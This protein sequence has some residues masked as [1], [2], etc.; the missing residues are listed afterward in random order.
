MLPAR[1]RDLGISGDE[2][3]ARYMEIIAHIAE[4]YILGR[5]LWFGAF[6]S[7]RFGADWIRSIRLFYNYA[8]LVS[9]SMFLDVCL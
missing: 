3:V 4:R 7:C 2:M 5:R 6:S 1:T 8:Y 9:L